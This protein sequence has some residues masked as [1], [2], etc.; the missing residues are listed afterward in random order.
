MKIT[1]KVNRRHDQIV[2]F[3]SSSVPTKSGGNKF[4]LIHMSDF[5]IRD[6]FVGQI[7]ALVRLF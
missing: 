5:S 7:W 4:V 1:W 3:V 2:L 6:K